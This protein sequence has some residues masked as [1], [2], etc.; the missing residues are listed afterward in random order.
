MSE[1][2][3][4]PPQLKQPPF[5]L[6]QKAHEILQ[7]IE[8]CDYKLD[9]LGLFIKQVQQFDYGLTAEVEFATLLAWLDQC[10][11]V[12]RL[13]QKVWSSERDS[14]WNVPDLFAVFRR[15]TDRFSAMI[16]VKTTNDMERD[17]K[18]DYIEHLRRYSAVHSQPLLIAW[19]PRSVGIW[20][21]VSADCLKPGGDMLKL[22]LETAWKNNLMGCLGGDF[23]VH[24]YEGCGLFV[25]M[26]RD[27]EKQ[28][29]AN[30]YSARY[31]IEKAEWR[32]A[33]GNSYE[34]LP[35]P[36]SSI[37]L[38][39]AV[40]CEFVEDPYCTQAFVCDGSFIHAQEILRTVA[41]F[42]LDDDELVRWNH[43]YGNFD[44]ILSREQ[45]HADLQRYFGIFV[46]YVIHQLPS[47][48]PG[49]LPEVWRT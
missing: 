26:H 36:I 21:L 13:D 29:T 44:A 28:P 41:R 11:M 20:F 43:V 34:Q 48:W 33:N 22:D 15:G 10:E 45:L 5:K 8:A 4:L 24:R 7:A 6:N 39:K 42:W 3:D 32:D 27:S 23:S 12:H 1:E 17:F 2:F 35:Q 18:P 40:S 30:G 14:K 19:R 16:E 25:V 47:T 38:T 31:T 46:Q 9:D 49:F 37:L